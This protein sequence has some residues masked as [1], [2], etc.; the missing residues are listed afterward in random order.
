MMWNKLGGLLFFLLVGFV[1]MGQPTLS[2]SSPFGEMVYV[3][4]LG[5]EDLR[6]LFCQEKNVDERFLHTLV[7]TYRYDESRPSLPRGNYLFVQVKGN[8]V[9][10]TT[11]AEDDLRYEFLQDR[12]VR[13]CLFDGHGELIPDARVRLNGKLLQ[14][15]PALGLYITKRFGRDKVLEIEHQGVFHY[16]SLNSCGGGVFKTIRRMFGERREKPS[17][18]VF[19]KP[20]YRLGDSVKFKA[21]IGSRN[22]KFIRKPL[23]VHLKGPWR[24]DTVLTEL[25]PYRPGMYHYAFKLTDLLQLKLN[26]NYRIYLGHSSRSRSYVGSSFRVEEYDLKHVRFEAQTTT[27]HHQK[28]QPPKFTLRVRDENDLAVLSG[29]F[30]IAVRPSSSYTFLDS[31]AFV[32]DV[33]WKYVGDVQGKASQE[34]TLP[35]TI[36]PPGVSFRYV[37]ECSYF[38]PDNDCYK[39]ELNVY[40]DGGASFIQTEEERGT[41][42]IRQL[43]RG[44][45]DS[46][47]ARLVFYAQDGEE[48]FRETVRL[49]YRLQVPGTASYC[50]I[51]TNEIRKIYT[52]SGSEQYRAIAWEF[53]KAADS[54][55]L[56]VDNPK[57]YPF[58]YKVLEGDKLIAEGYTTTLQEAWK[59]ARRADYQLQISYLYGGKLQ[60]FSDQILMDTKKANIQLS[61]PMVVSPGQTTSVGVKVTNYKGEPVADADVT[62]YAVTSKFGANP[63]GVKYSIPFW[64]KKQEQG[65][66]DFYFGNHEKRLL[67]H[68]E[69][70]S[71]PYWRGKLG[72]SRYYQ[73]LYP[74]PVFVHTEAAPGNVTQIAPYVILDGEVGRSIVVKIDQ[75]LYYYYHTGHLPVYSFPIS[76]GRHALSIRIHDREVYLDSIHVEAGKKTIVSIDGKASIPEAGIR[77]VFK[78]KKEIGKLSLS[79]RTYLREHLFAVHSD[80]EG[81]QVFGIPN[82]LEVPVYVTSGDFVYYLNPRKE[83]SIRYRQKHGFVLTGPLPT[84]DSAA[85][86]V[87][88]R[89]AAR[90]KPVGGYDYT[91]RGKR[92]QSDSLPA[93]QIQMKFWNYY[94]EKPD[95]GAFALRRED[96]LRRADSG[97]L[98]DLKQ[99]TFVAINRSR[100]PWENKLAERY[101]LQLHL[102]EKQDSAAL[103][104][105]LFLD[106]EKRLLEAYPGG[107]RSFKG[108]P[109]EHLHM[110]LVFEDDS[111]HERAITLREHG[112]NYLSLD[113]VPRCR[114]TRLQEWLKQVLELKA[115]TAADLKRLTQPEVTLSLDTVGKIRVEGSVYYDKQ[116]PLAG[117]VLLIAGTQEG[118]STDEHGHFRLYARAG[119][120]IICSSFGCK[121]YTFVVTPNNY[122]RIILEDEVCSLDE[123]VVR[124]KSSNDIFLPEFYL[125]NS[126]RW[127]FAKRERVYYKKS[128][129]YDEEVPKQGYIPSFE[130]KETPFIILNGVPYVGSLADI[131]P[132]TIVSL[133]QILPERAVELYGAQGSQGVLIVTTSEMEDGET[134]GVSLRRDFRDDAFWQPA[135]RTDADG[136]ATFTVTYPDD[137]TRWDMRFIAIGN[138]RESGYLEHVVKSF[139]AVNARLSLPK[140]VLQGDSSQFVGRLNAYLDDSIVA[141]RMVA[142]QGEEYVRDV[143]FKESHVD[144]LPVKVVEDDSLRVTYSVKTSDGL[145]DGEQQTIPVFLPGVEEYSGEFQVLKTDSIYHFSMDTTLGEAI[146]YADVSGLELLL[147]EMDR[148]VRYPYACNEQMASKVKALLM[149]RRIYALLQRPFKEQRQIERLLDRLKKNQ[150]EKA[151]WGWWNR[152]EYVAWVSV[153]VLE[154]LLAAKQAGYQ[155]AFDERRAVQALLTEIEVAL[156]RE[157]NVRKSDLLNLLIHLKESGVEINYSAYMAKLDSLPDRNVQ[158]K[159]LGWRLRQL[160]GLPVERDWVLPYM[161]RS[162][163]GNLYCANGEGAS[164]YSPHDNA[165]QHTLLA[166]KI[167]RDMGDN[168]EILEQIR[169]YFFEIRR[170]GFW[171]NT[172]EGASIMEVILPDLVM[173]QSILATNLEI[174]GEVCRSFPFNKQYP[175]GID[176]E[177][178]KIGTLPLFFTVHQ[179]GWTPFPEKVSQGFLVETRFRDRENGQTVDSLRVGREVEL[180]VRVSNSSD[181]EYVLLEI[182]ILAGCSYTSMAQKGWG[183]EH[184]EYGKEKVSIFCKRLKAGEHEFVIQLLPRFVGKYHLNPAKAELMY[185]PTIFGRERMK[186]ITIY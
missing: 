163:M 100:F 94:E 44:K 10:Y 77:V 32:P 173:L 57:D 117:A 74:S 119:D 17:F 175:A 174:N 69:T 159:L 168:D 181:A 158:C 170:S 78:R 97:V 99:G 70:L 150:N 155:V 134:R 23:K 68:T 147:R 30:E 76:P 115:F 186:C 84:S 121:P 51:Q 185:F 182:P 24:K 112:L 7:T 177:V 146:V 3:Y 104:F 101:K 11:H 116:K 79:E 28:M 82:Y 148:I 25:I 50:T 136:K 171:N 59:A 16:V 165:V 144:C 90:F 102:I 64:G 183:N 15:D 169:N 156:R 42:W 141:Q 52:F 55:Y 164:R 129:Y 120:S 179:S 20:K 86:H 122:Y 131:D 151:L 132:S 105:V 36:F 96:V 139:K 61:T 18:L 62:A 95:L 106:Q 31:T 178:K 43:T 127:L 81:R 140:F 166:Y 154:A 27:T 9:E 67:R 153:Q 6:A 160:V 162:V 152:E 75:Q 65:Y 143:I 35:D 87:G 107:M 172:Y 19:N 98:V 40:Y 53:F 85:L 108:L 124:G 111:Y 47:T 110:I 83:E 33:L 93:K 176:L 103:L 72:K 66:N 128:G 80:I 8:K 135:L 46:T 125:R 41:V 22:G 123:V 12:D 92:V 1:G 21:F 34:F 37:I 149:K 137:L 109:L 71:W 26:N 13:L 14:Y 73:F 142:L 180:C 184:R 167:L 39:K 38:T 48:V 113:A 4:R 56:R 91:I 118:G 29:R 2:K 145:F 49:P 161:R 60:T 58:W 138:K 133:K 89:V 45:V 88:G 63:L 130:E 54:L 157:D 126:K 5:V 114:S